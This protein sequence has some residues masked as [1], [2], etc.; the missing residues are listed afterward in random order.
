MNM[1][2]NIIAETMTV[3]HTAVIEKGGLIEKRDKI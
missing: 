1:V 2:K 3:V